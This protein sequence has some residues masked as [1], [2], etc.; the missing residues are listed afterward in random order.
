MP[1]LPEYG[2]AVL[3]V[4]DFKTNAKKTAVEADMFTLTPTNYLISLYVIVRHYISEDLP[5]V[6]YVPSIVSICL[7]ASLRQQLTLMVRVCVFPLVFTRRQ[8]PLGHRLFFFRSWPVAET[9]N[10]H[11]H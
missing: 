10:C 2:V 9:G 7:Q 8:H 5:P 1:L 11:Y 3:Y 6:L 4:L